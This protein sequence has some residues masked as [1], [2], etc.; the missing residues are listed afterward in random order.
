MVRWRGGEV[1][2]WRGGE[3]VERWWCVRRKNS[4]FASSVFIPAD[5]EHNSGG[6]SVASSIPRYDGRIFIIYI[7]Q[8][9]KDG[10]LNNFVK[11]DYKSD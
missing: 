7:A 9:L 5:V 8:V 6:I 3:V 4:K 10:E 2:R 1:V 11:S